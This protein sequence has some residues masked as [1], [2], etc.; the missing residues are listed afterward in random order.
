MAGTCREVQDGQKAD[1]TD[2]AA[3]ST[4]VDSLAG[5]VSQIR[6]EV[7]GW[8][9]TARTPASARRKSLSGLPLNR[10]YKQNPPPSAV[11]GVAAPISG[12][13]RPPFV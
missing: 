2:E 10:E 9:N 12:E 3:N 1:A 11:A 8:N 6:G 4:F 13:A 5:T 7:T